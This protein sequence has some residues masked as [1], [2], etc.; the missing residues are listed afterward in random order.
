MKT[1]VD[2]FVRYAHNDSNIFTHLY[3]ESLLK[4]IKILNILFYKSKIKHPH[5][6]LKHCGPFEI[7]ILNFAGK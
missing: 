2:F 6:H 3:T 5:P 4:M 1:D 7:K